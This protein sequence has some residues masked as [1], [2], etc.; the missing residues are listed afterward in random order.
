[1]SRMKPS[2]WAAAW[3]AGWT[4]VAAAAAP[5]ASQVQLTQA[6]GSRT[7]TISYTLD[8]DAIIT[9]GIETNGVALPDGVVTRLSGDV[10]RRVE[11]GA[12]A[13][14]WEAGVEWPSNVTETARARVKAWRL[15]A[16]P[17]FLVI[18]LSGGPASGT[19]PVHYYETL[20]ALPFG[21]LTNDTY[22]SERLV[23]RKLRRG[24]FL[25]GRG[26]SISRTMT[27]TKDFYA[28]IFEVTQGQWYNVMGDY[29]S[30]Y[31]ANR[32]VRPVEQVAYNRI[33]GATTDT[34][35]IDWPNTGALVHPDS[36]LGTLRSRSGLAAVDLPTETQWEYACRAGT[37][38]IFNCGSL[39]AT[40]EGA[41]G[42]GQNPWLDPIARYAFN[43]G[44]QT[45]TEDTPPETGGTAVVGSYLPNAWGLYDTIGNVM[46]LV[47]DWWAGDTAGTF[48]ANGV[49]QAG[50]TSGTS[51]IRRSGGDSQPQYAN[52]VFRY[53]QNPATASKNIGFRVVM[54]ID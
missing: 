46:E 36:F 27:L 42:T 24:S 34:P 21:G 13:M 48:P 41:Y 29:P 12:R 50:P 54:V 10:C 7:V 5:E 19:Y 25:M 39:D 30:F 1:M 8:A 17:P 26:T 37:R 32:L 28:G 15:D 44:G 33:R 11:A 9:V 6:P 45:A 51:R 18:D 23:M 47:R 3:A 2:V 40:I 49:D 38:T 22:R 43:G 16:P 31:T 52:T 14:T 53:N 4:L 20:D 35:A